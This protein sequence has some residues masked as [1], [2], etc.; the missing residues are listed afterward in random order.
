MASRCKKKSL[1]NNFHNSLFLQEAGIHF[2]TTDQWL[3][4]PAFTI[5]EY[6]GRYSGSVTFSFWLKY[7]YGNGGY[8]FRYC[9]SGYSSDHLSVYLQ[10]DGKL[11]IFLADSPI[12]TDPIIPGQ[13]K[14]ITITYV[15]YSDDLSYVFAFMDTTLLIYSLGP[16]VNIDFYPD[17]IFIIGGPPL[18]FRGSL[19]NFRVFSPGTAVISDACNFS[20]RLLSPINL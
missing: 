14:V 11:T 2:T 12:E 19:A 5:P 1:K 18:T 4:L 6:A 9:D 16:T 20:L 8:I 10:D 13:W 7:S 15:L 17:D 3:T